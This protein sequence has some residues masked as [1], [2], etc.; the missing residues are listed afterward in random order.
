MRIWTLA[1]VFFALGSVVQPPQALAQIYRYTAK[2]GTAVFTDQLSDLPPERRAYYAKRKKEADKKLAAIRAAQ[3]PEARA[4]ADRAEEARRQKQ[5]AELE[6]QTAENR[7]KFLQMTQKLK[8][9]GK[10]KSDE[11][12][13]WKERIKDAEAEL[14]AALAAY[15]KAKKEWASL[16]VNATYTLFPGQ[17]QR[18]QEVQASLPE[19]AKKV[20]AANEYLTE[21]IPQEAKKA[22]VPPGWLR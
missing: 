20:E 14:D 13:Y 22:G 6:R 4:K 3:S 2:D 7:T 15:R 1:L 10:R 5:K 21:T 9:E 17:V 18:R 12:R 16:S 8:A 19:L 11:K